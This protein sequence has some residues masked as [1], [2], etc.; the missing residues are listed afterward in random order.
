MTE[1]KPSQKALERILKGEVKQ[2]PRWFFV[3]KNILMWIFGGASILVGAL[4]VSVIIYTVVNSDMD[5][6][7]EIYGYFISY[8]TL[9]MIFLWIFLTGVF[10]I[11]C[12]VSVRHTDRGY[13]YPLYIIISIHIGLSII[14]GVFLYAKGISCYV[15]DM[16]G[17]HMRYYYNVNKRR[18]VSFDLPERGILMG[19][20]VRRNDNIVELMSTDGTLWVIAVDNI[21]TQKYADLQGSD[22]AIFLGNTNEKGVF[23]ACDVKMRSINGMQVVSFDFDD[24][25]D[26][27]LLL[28]EKHYEMIRQQLNQMRAALINPCNDIRWR[29]ER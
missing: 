10:V 2:K 5:L 26:E 27:R 1:S 6:H 22:H 15:D 19:Q 12:D 24:D 14:V 8:I 17:S 25:N 11:L 18:A 16:L 20:I 7:R 28:R 3:V 9:C 4:F 29:L 21:P 23:I 13:I